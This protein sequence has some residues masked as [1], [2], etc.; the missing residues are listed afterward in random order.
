MKGYIAEKRGKVAA[1]EEGLLKEP[2][3]QA[4]RLKAKIRARVEHPFHIVKNL[5]RQRKR[6]YR[7]LA[8]NAA[9]WRVLFAPA[10]PV[11]AKKAL[12]A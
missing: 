8:K 9:P 1:M 12:L 2:T 3:V 6:R 7:G 11:I 4:E 5:L 10:N